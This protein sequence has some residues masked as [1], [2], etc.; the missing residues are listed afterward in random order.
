MLLILLIAI[1]FHMKSNLWQFAGYG[2]CHKSFSWLFIY[3]ITKSVGQSQCNFICSLGRT[4]FW[5]IRNWFIYSYNCILWKIDLAR[6]LDLSSVNTMVFFGHPFIENIVE[7]ISQ[8][9]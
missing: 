7:A 4:C 1:E 6:A 2:S 5:S 3:L 8:F 9:N